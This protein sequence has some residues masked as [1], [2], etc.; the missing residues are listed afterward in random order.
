MGGLGSRT[1]SQTVCEQNAVVLQCFLGVWGH[2]GRPD[3]PW[4][5]LAGPAPEPSASLRTV[6]GREG[7]KFR[8][9]PTDRLGYISASPTL[10]E[11]NTMVLQ[12]FL[13]AWG[14]FGSPQAA[15]T[16]ETSR[17]LMGGGS[18]WWKVEGRKSRIAR[19][20]CFRSKTAS[21]TPPGQIQWFCNDFEGCGCRG[22]A[23]SF[24]KLTPTLPPDTH[25]VRVRQLARF[26]RSQ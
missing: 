1:G 23:M 17:N 11:Q 18:G 12:C 21:W 7:R 6:V 19:T 15:P 9:G 10:P 8:S 24:E 22:F 14:H 2:S 13:A 26:G 20:D 25:Y 5:P 16:P 3:R 4:E